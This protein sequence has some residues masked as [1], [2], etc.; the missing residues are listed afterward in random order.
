[1]SEQFDANKEARK[2][3]DVANRLA[4][5]GTKDEQ[6]ETAE[7]ADNLRGELCGLT[8]Q[9][10][11]KTLAKVTAPGVEDTHVTRDKDGKAISLEFRIT[12]F[13]FMGMDLECRQNH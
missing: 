11:E 12:D 8:P 13:W 2:V 10:L 5:A 9:Q 6:R 4:D 3:F 7:A 1:M